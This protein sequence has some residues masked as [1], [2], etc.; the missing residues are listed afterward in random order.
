M[1]GVGQRIRELRKAAHLTQQELADGVVTR[2]Y[3]SQIE[4]GMIQPSYDTLEKLARKLS[5]PVEDFFKE[6]ENTALLVADA[7][8]YIRF[9]EGQVESGQ[10]DQAKRTLENVKA[11]VLGELND[12]DH[13][14]LEWVKGKLVEDIDSDLAVTHYQQSL[15]RLANILYIRE[16]VRTLNSLGYVHSQERRD[17]EGLQTLN[18]AY[19]LVLQHQIGGPLKVNVLVN[20]GLAHAK[21]SEYRSA[22][23]LLQEAQKIN[24]LTETHTKSG[25]IF[26]GLALCCMFTE[27]Y[28]RSEGLYRRAIDF[29]RSQEDTWNVAANYLNLG[30][31]YRKRKMYPEALEAVRTALHWWQPAGDKTRLCNAWLE[32]ALIHLDL[33]DLEAADRC[34]HEAEALGLSGRNQA[35][36]FEVRAARAR[37]ERDFAQAVLHLGQ[38][39]RLYEELKLS[40]QML[41]LELQ[42]SG[43]VLHWAAAATREQSGEHL[44]QMGEV[45]F[46]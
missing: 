2:S 40:K 30:I 12:F 31:Q 38:A 18:D 21:L 23:R 9:A 24:E 14:I 16:R 44:R 10:L 8:K 19:E 17:E 25:H 37:A 33:N 43:S 28:E 6:P 20:L 36:V 42:I 5:V 3:I 35:F 29:Y 13:G 39:Y 1:G 34:L 27:Q 45:M 22:M 32:M 15:K 11:E 7:K 41:D 4:K 46:S 26:A